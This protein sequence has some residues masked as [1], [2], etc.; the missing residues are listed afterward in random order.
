M[1]S[2]SVV[3]SGSG[4]QSSKQHE[5]E[6][7]L[8]DVV[9]RLGTIEALVQPMQAV[10]DQLHALEATVADQGQQEVA[11]ILALTSGLVQT[12]RHWRAYLWGCSFLIKIDHFSLKFLLDNT[13]G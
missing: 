8:A 13:S 5:Q 3:G 2:T 12:V 7:S 1:S 11:L 6:V 10:P 4:Q 9:K